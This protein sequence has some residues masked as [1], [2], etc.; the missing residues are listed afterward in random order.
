[1]MIFN[2]PTY[3]EA[4]NDEKESEIE[5]VSMG[6]IESNSPKIDAKKYPLIS[7]LNPPFNDKN[8]KA[9][10]LCEIV[11]YQQERWAHNLPKNI[12]IMT[13][14]NAP[15]Y[16]NPYVEIPNGTSALSVWN[17]T[18]RIKWM[19]S[20]RLNWNLGELQNNV[21]HA[22]RGL[23]SLAPN[24]FLKVARE[25]GYF[26]NISPKMSVTFWIAMTDAA[27]LRLSQ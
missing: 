9:S 13:N 14:P 27:K 10:L 17:V 6:T 11:T 22:I 21:E 5:S 1:M 19:M 2:T 4:D 16:L 18:K 7:S 25:K 23:E 24:A 12:F 8:T 15:L 20:W 26:S 3:K